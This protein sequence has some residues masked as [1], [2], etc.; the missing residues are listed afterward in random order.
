MYTGTIMVRIDIYKKSR[1]VLYFLYADKMRSKSFILNENR[2]IRDNNRSFNHP[3]VTV[4]SASSLSISPF[5]LY[6]IL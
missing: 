5:S 6:A 3:T 4:D 2:W 1:G